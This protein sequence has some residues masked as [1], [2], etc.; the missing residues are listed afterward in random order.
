MHDA[1][2][3][4]TNRDPIEP[5]PGHDVA[6]QEIADTHAL[7]RLLV[8]THVRNEERLAS[9]G[10]GALIGPL[11]LE[12]TCARFDPRHERPVAAEH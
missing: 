6:A 8:H 7:C 11:D 10:I 12:L 4:I 1:V 2:V 9:A 5:D 3:V